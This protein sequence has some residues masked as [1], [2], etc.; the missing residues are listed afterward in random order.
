MYKLRRGRT[1]VQSKLEP[2]QPQMVT[3]TDIKDVYR[4]KRDGSLSVSPSP[5]M[6]N[7]RVNQGSVTGKRIIKDRDRSMPAI[8]P[9]VF[10]VFRLEKTLSQAS[11]ATSKTLKRKR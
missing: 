3:E 7:D 11:D 1:D 4:K 6:R 5:T 9:E 2:I 10:H 8:R